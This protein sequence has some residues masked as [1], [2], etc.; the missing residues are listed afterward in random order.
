MNEF[1]LEAWEVPVGRDATKTPARVEFGP[2]EWNGEKTMISALGVRLQSREVVAF[3]H[4]DGVEA[5]FAVLQGQSLC[6]F[7]SQ[8]DIGKLERIVRQSIKGEQF[9]CGRLFYLEGQTCLLSPRETVW[10]APRSQQWDSVF[11]FP[12]DAMKE[13]SPRV[14]QWL[15]QQWNE[16]HSEVR[17]AWEWNRK[18]AQERHE[19]LEATVW[20][21]REL[22]DVM[23][24]AA[25][26]EELPEH[27]SWILDHVD[28][29]NH[30]PELLARL[31]PWRELIET[32]FLPFEPLPDSA[33]EC[34]RDYFQFVSNHIQVEGENCSERQHLEARLE[35]RQWLEHNAPDEIER[36]L[37][38]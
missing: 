13:P 11:S 27:A 6:P 5:N 35:L 8:L 17:F 2:V 19:F 36:L 31:K 38:K 32:H 16:P 28:T 20:R 22:F 7:S 3:F 15:Q 14:F 9:S 26:I 29:H 12:F 21:W 33:P 25:I 24:A 10:V 4:P 1:L 34:L 23:R 37:P 18:N 30:S